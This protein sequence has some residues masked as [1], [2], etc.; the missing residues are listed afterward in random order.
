MV[1]NVEVLVGKPNDLLLDLG[2]AGFV[3]VNTNTR[4]AWKVAKRY[5]VVKIS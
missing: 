2:G 1:W 5:I 4:S 3:H